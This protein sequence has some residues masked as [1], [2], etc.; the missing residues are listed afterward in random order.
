MPR[1]AGSVATSTPSTS[2][3]PQTP[4]A[5]VDQTSGDGN[6]VPAVKSKAKA[7]AK[8]KAKEVKVQ[9]PL[10]R[11]EDLTRQIPKKKTECDELA[12]QIGTLPYGTGVKQE[13]DKFSDKFQRRPQLWHCHSPQ[14][15]V[16]LLAELSL[17]N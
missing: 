5:A 10:Q 13:L 6:V 17:C 7:K 2:A 1:P 8:P 12:L 11:G 3:A 4:Q 9:T 14:L 15:L 16:S